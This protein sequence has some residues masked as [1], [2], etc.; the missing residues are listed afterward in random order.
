MHQQLSIIVMKSVLKFALL[1]SLIVTGKLVKQPTQATAGQS[2]AA[3]SVKNSTSVVLV[4]QVLTSEP[5]KPAREQLQPQQ[6]GNGLI[7]EMF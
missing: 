5:V 3:K 4:H 6:S 2:V 7:A 1:A